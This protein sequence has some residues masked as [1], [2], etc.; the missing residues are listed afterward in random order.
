M[1]TDMIQKVLLS[2]RDINNNYNK[3]IGSM[4]KHSRL[5][6]NLTLE[7]VSKDICSISYLCKVENNQIVPSEKNKPKLFERLE[8]KEE[9]LTYQ[10]SDQWIKDILYIRVFQ[11]NFF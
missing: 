7:D 10:N 1:V 5:N 6:K 11:K 2:H 8:I 9:D 3:T 4:L